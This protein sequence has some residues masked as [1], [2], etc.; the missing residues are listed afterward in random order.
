M[1]FYSHRPSG[2]ETFNGLD[3]GTLDPRILSTMM[4]EEARMM[5]GSTKAVSIDRA[6]DRP[7]SG[8]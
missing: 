7:Q 5:V 1:A 2:L 8:P 6:V 3:F 4:L